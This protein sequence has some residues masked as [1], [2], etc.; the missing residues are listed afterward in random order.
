MYLDCSGIPN[1][2]LVV[3]ILLYFIILDCCGNSSGPWVAAGSSYIVFYLQIGF[4]VI[5][6]LGKILS[7][8]LRKFWW[9]F[10][11]AGPIAGAVLSV[12][13]QSTRFLFPV[14]PILLSNTI[15]FI[16]YW[17]VNCVDS[18][19][20]YHLSISLIYLRIPKLAGIRKLELLF[21]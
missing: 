16:L 11:K 1:S 15:P 4:G 21:I 14:D 17:T 2:F 5:Q 12:W 3:F 10:P 8:F 18:I 7:K 20:D 13:Y 19:G 6:L 9:N